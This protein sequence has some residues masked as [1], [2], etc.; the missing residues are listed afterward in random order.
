VKIVVISSNRSSFNKLRSPMKHLKGRCDLSL[1]VTSSHMLMNSGKTQ[2]EIADSGFEIEES[3]DSCLE[4]NTLESM[5]ISASILTQSLAQAMRKSKP[6]AIMVVGD[7]YDTLPAVM[8]ALYMNVKVIHLQGGEVSG[9]IDETIRHMITK[10]SHLHFPATENAARIILQMGEDPRYVYNVGCTVIDNMVEIDAKGFSP[11]ALID[12]KNFDFTDD[13]PYI[14]STFHPVVT[15]YGSI[16]SNFQKYVSALETLK[17]YK[18]VMFYPNIDAGSSAIVRMMRK[19]EQ[20]PSFYFVKHMPFPDYVCLMAN[21][22][23]VIGNSSSV[24]RETGYYGVPSVNVGNRQSGREH[25]PNVIDS[26]NETIEI[27]VAIDKAMESGRLKNTLY[28]DGRAGEKIAAYVLENLDKVPL[29]KSFTQYSF[30][31]R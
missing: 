16:E 31:Q 30:E 6:D 9:S 12:P 2:K 17:A 25:G 19:L 7:R 26:G 29:Q 3:F 13:E 14:I 18:K 22:Q 24:V 4:S 23:L 27:L 15:E 28:G 20:D 5:C 1:W 11:D 21:A 8:A 10:A